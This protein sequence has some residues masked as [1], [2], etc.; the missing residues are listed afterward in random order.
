MMKELIAA[1]PEQIRESIAIAR[2]TALKPMGAEIRNVVISGLGGSGIGGTIVADLARPVAAVPVV[3]NKEYTIPAFADKHTLF[4]ASSYSGGTE[5]TLSAFHHALQQGAHIVCITSGGQLAE[6]A[7]KHNLSLLQIPGGN[8]PRAC[9]GYSLS[10]LIHVL[11]HYQVIP[12]EYFQQL[13]NA[14]GFIEKHTAAMS[15]AGMKWAETLNGRRLAIYADAAIEGVAV[16][17][18]QQL[19][20]NAKML[21]WH[22]VVPEMNHNELV[23]WTEPNEEVAVIFLRNETDYE[24]NQLRMN[25]NKNIVSRY[26][27]HVYEINSEGS[28]AVERLLYHIHLE[29]WISY[30]LSQLRGVDVMEIRVIDYLKGEL[31]RV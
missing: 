31:S 19:N 27:P 14:I 12:A 8:P 10:E 18:R 24:R 22:H 30:H 1:F 5:E 11:A 3:V 20:E 25:I 21:A 15:A 16:R 13:E 6:E 23:G 7:R 9:L 26:T 2:A 17:F 4:I 28:N 29:D